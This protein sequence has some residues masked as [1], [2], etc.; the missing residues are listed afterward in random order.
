MEAR[1]KGS[2]PMIPAGVGPKIMEMGGFTK[3]KLIAAI[4]FNAPWAMTAGQTL[5]D[6]SASQPMNIPTEMQNHTMAIKP[7]Q[8]KPG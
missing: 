1:V 4:P 7:S 2:T 3:N 5:S 6:F 8:G